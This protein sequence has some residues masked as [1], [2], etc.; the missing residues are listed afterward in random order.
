MT[1][2]E[3]KGLLMKT[4]S[5]VYTLAAVISIFFAGCSAILP[6]PDL[7]GLYN[8]A[9]S[10]G[11]LDR[12][13]IIL[14]PGV[15][16]S[17]LVDGETDTI[18][19]GAFRG[20]FA[21]PDSDKGFR[22]IAHPVGQGRELAELQDGV[23]A[24][25]V[26]DRL[27]IAFIGL[28]VELSAYVQLLR[29]LGVG[30]YRDQELSESGSIDYGDEHFTCFQFPYDWRR[31]LSENAEALHRFIEDRKRY[32]QAELKER[33]G[34]E[35]P[36]IK[37]DIVAHSMGGL[38]TRYY[39]RYGGRRL[40]EDGSIPPVDWSG[41]K[42]VERAVL[43]GTPSAG[44]VDGLAVL[45][46]GISFS[47]LLPSYSAALVGTMPGLYQLLPRPRH[48][49]VVDIANPDTALNIYDPALWQQLGWGL[50]SPDSAEDLERLLPEI[51]DPEKRRQ[52]ALDHQ[53]KSLLRAQQFA[54]AVDVPAK[55]PEG[56]D[57]FLFAGDAVDTDKTIGVDMKSGRIQRIAKGPGDGSVLRTSALMDERVGSDWSPG[58]R[59]PVDWTNVTFLFADH[60]GMTRE[61][62]FVDNVLYLMLE[63]PR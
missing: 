8:R 26:L 28:P 2:K 1:K 18:V 13:P 19:W 63:D 51:D 24:S 40:P 53:R 58:L 57:I 20:D 52:A 10:T 55:R 23:Y 35:K 36:D 11:D 47:A 44:S 59:T 29:T 16:G 61:P 48:A 38:L 30:G 46:E 14:I 12:N 39:L 60:L 56:L 54:A 33:Y 31:D 7:G 43:I 21:D 17:R 25:G 42:N 49:A 9:A 15:I 27:Q 5:A 37:F 22:L 50:A 45:V 34:M 32:V 4:V 6:P 3:Q 41:A 62:V